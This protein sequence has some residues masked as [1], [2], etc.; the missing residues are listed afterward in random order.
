[1][2]VT[3]SPRVRNERGGPLLLCRIVGDCHVA[4]APRKDVKFQ[5]ITKSLWLGFNG[6]NL[7]MTVLVPSFWDFHYS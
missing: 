3:A 1:M 5:E 7:R 4:I 2:P 6:N